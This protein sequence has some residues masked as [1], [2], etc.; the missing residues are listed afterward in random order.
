MAP[1]TVEDHENAILL[2]E[3]VITSIDAID[4]DIGSNEDDVDPL[5]ILD[6]DL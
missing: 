6:D 2:L 1:L 4:S 3:T 5:D